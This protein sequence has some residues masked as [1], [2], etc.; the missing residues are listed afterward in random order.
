MD[1]DGHLDLVDSDTNAVRVRRGDG[2]LGFH[3]GYD[4]ATGSLA[5][6]AAVADFDGDGH[7][8]VVAG[9]AETHHLVFLRNR[10]FERCDA[11]ELPSRAGNVD[12]GGGGASADVLFLNGSAGSA[13]AREVLV[14][15]GSPAT[16]DVARPPAGGGGLY[17]IWIFDGEPCEGTPAEAFVKNGPGSQ[18][19]GVASFC[20][21]S[22]N[23]VAPGSCPCPRT[24]P[25]GFTSRAI[26]GAGVA[27][28]LCLHRAPAHPRAPASL[29]VAFP[30][31]T[32]TI[33]GLIVDPNAPTGPKKVAIT[34]AVV[35]R[36]AP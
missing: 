11:P 26:Q 27:A 13:P 2:A 10:H 17:A 25:A 8:D 14:A 36:V 34:N 28:S 22:N 5:R 7:A 15:H 1:E 30:P 20:L 18:S 35:A 21:P 9:D 23:A 24:F 31:G 16:L 12:T 29:A 19:V 6:V 33:Q 32:F 3:P 4:H